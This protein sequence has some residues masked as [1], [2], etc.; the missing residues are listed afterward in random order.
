[1]IQL[2]K[3]RNDAID[4]IHQAQK[5]YPIHTT[6]NMVKNNLTL[7]IQG[8][9]MY[10]PCWCGKPGIG[11]TAHAKMIA[12]AMG[13]SLL[14]VSM[15]KP[16]EYFTGLPT[17]N[18]VTFDDDESV[19]E[20]MY[21]YWSMPDMIHAANVMARK[22]DTNGCIIFMDDLH[23]ISPDVQT[24]FF[25]LVLE[26]SLNNFKLDKN[27]AMLAAMNNSNMAGFDGF[28]SAINNRVQRINVSMSWKYWYENCGAELNPYIAGFLRNFPNNIEE[29]E[30][31]EEPFCT[32]RSWTTL[33]KLLEPITKQ[34]MD[35]TDKDKKWFI[36][37]IGMHA[38]GFMSSKTVTMLKANIGQQLQYDY[39]G[40]VKN[41]KYFIDKNDPISQFC[42][43]NIIR[44]LRDE[45]DLDN[46]IA[47]IK[48]IMA[49]DTAIKDYSNAIINIMYELSAFSHMYMKRPDDEES[50]TRR[51]LIKSAQAKMFEAGGS[52]IHTLIYNLTAT[53]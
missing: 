33:S 48:K 31:T 52:K 4:A 34:Y 22:K 51:A 49:E 37:Q 43:G 6:L 1:M 19:K 30:S 10:I 3:I 32:Y 44:Y 53:V 46:M 39:E 47:Y 36:Q 8:V 50:K 9:P 29:P 25:E 2:S 35:A 18:K 28:F 42:F 14:Y 16:Y 11:K 20:K 12:D 17:P 38:A 26:R 23:I 5:E 40:M 24:M 41:N 27:V 13:M 21:V 15:A 7:Q 45:K